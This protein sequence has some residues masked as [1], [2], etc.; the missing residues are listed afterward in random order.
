MP[1][2][3]Y[4][5]ATAL[6][7]HLPDLGFTPS[8]GDH[9]L[10]RRF[11]RN[12]EIQL[13][14]SYID[15]GTALFPHDHEY[16]TFVK[17]LQSPQHNGQTFEL[18][19]AQVQEETLGCKVQQA[20]HQSA[21]G[22]PGEDGYVDP[23]TIDVDHGENFTLIYQPGLTQQIL[24]L[25][26]LTKDNT[27]PTQVPIHKTLAKLLDETIP[28]RAAHAA[29]LAKKRA[30]REAKQRHEDIHDATDAFD[31][32]DDVSINETE[33]YNN[34]T[35][36]EKAIY[37]DLQPIYGVNYRTIVGKLLYLSR[38]T[39]PDI[40]T[41]T[42]ILSR[43]VSKPG[44]HAMQALKQVC[45]YL[46]GTPRHG[47]KYTE[48]PA[49][50]K[51]EIRFYADSNYPVGRARLGYVALIGYT[52]DDG[53][54]RGQAIDWHS[55]LSATTSNSTAEAELYAAYHGFTRALALKKDLDHAQITDPGT[56]CR[57][58]EDN[59]A[60][61]HQFNT[62]LLRTSLTWIG[63]KYLRSLELVAS[64][65]ITVEHIMSKLNVADIM[66]KA[67]LGT[68]EHANFRSIMMGM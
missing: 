7:T 46:K 42:S 37:A 33:S 52:A 50:K 54:F 18:G 67:T 63:N 31:E 29:L 28:L 51:V 17:E 6:D 2:A 36:E 43:Y 12:N 3:G 13:Y 64:G 53:S 9:N 58:F 27:K 44:F 30:C 45:R 35:E 8:R 24:I 59:K 60:V 20:L 26:K 47:I 10:H 19:L 11:N 14:A 21:I 41:A 57:C 65:D 55:R 56:P 4:L 62:P 32:I 39:R 16:E 38:F 34:L 5:F 23:T 49:N 61:F 1:N 48:I 25:A 40:S 22:N 66:T 68:S 15:D